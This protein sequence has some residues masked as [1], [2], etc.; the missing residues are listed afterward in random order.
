MKSALEAQKT[1][2]EQQAA[3][4]QQQAVLF[5]QQAAQLEIQKEHLT[6]QAA[7]MHEK[8]AEL[9]QAKVQ[10]NTEREE[11]KQAAENQASQAAETIQPTPDATSESFESTPASSLAPPSHE[12][13][14]LNEKIEDL[15][16]QN[17]NFKEIIAELEQEIEIEKNN[18]LKE[19]ERTQSY[20]TN[21][22]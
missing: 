16:T 3:Q 20:E 15:E 18:L 22:V 17:S 14:S 2:D 5:K 8:M 21:Q 19:R 10:L 11:M 12:I 7:E 9:E 6:Q 4:L 1:V 13:D